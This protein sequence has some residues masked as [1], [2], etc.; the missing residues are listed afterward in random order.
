MKTPQ[1]ILVPSDFSQYANKAVEEALSLAKQFHAQVHLLHVVGDIQQ[2]AA[3]Y[4]LTTEM[5]D[6][7]RKTSLESSEKRLKE[8]LAKFPA[9][10]DVQV[11]ID[12]RLGSP[13]EEILKAEQEMNIDLIVIATH[14]KTGFLKQLMGSVADRVS[15]GAKGRVMLVKA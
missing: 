4:C 1:K 12:V 15:R 6:E 2:C 11:S 13:A 10:K 3:E 5:V 8:D 7:Y 14:G 9:A